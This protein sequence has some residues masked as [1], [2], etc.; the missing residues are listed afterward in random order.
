MLWTI[1]VVLVALWALGLVTSYTLGGFIHILLG[2]ATNIRRHYPPWLLYGVVGLLLVANTINIAADVSA[3]G[4]ASRLIAGGPAQL[5]AV[6]FGLVSLLLQ[7]L[8]PYH[9]YV[10]ILKWLTLA[11]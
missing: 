6:G 1:A 3:M 8:I 4:D 7:V 11:L 2:L 5:Y 10:R 9:R